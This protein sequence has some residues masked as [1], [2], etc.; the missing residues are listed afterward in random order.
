MWLEISSVDHYVRTF[1][2]CS[3]WHFKKGK[4]HTGNIKIYLNDQEPP[5]GQKH[6][7]SLSKLVQGNPDVSC[8]IVE[9]HR[10]GIPLTYEPVPALAPHYPRLAIAEIERR[11]YIRELNQLLDRTYAL[12]W[13]GYLDKA[14]IQLTIKPKRNQCLRPR[15]WI[16]LYGERE[17]DPC[18][19]IR[20]SEGTILQA[21]NSARNLNTFL[22][23]VG[24]HNLRHWDVTVTIGTRRQGWKQTKIAGW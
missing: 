21:M 5:R 6:M 1:Y 19:R 14:L 17:R 22:E 24:L 15:Q 2:P 7:L 23:G 16:I 9:E 11:Q 20:V 12:T 18:I 10:P 8:C 4:G 13:K 3:E